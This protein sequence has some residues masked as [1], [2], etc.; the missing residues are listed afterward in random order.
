MSRGMVRLAQSVEEKKY[1]VATNLITHF[2]HTDV[3]YFMI[4]YTCTWVK[5]DAVRINVPMWWLHNVIEA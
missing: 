5:Q 2:K 4:Y 3:F 1:Y